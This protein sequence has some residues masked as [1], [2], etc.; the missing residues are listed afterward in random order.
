MSKN[1]LIRSIKIKRFERELNKVKNEGYIHRITSIERHTFA[2]GG[3]Q[4]I[5]TEI[6]FTDFVTDDQLKKIRTY[7]EREYN[8]V[9]LNFL[10]ETGKLPKILL[11]HYDEKVI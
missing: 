11:I 2:S 4:T 1:S 9:V 10:L 6:L 7:I 8:F 3:I 5:G